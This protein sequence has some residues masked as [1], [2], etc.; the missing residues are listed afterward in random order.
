MNTTLFTGHYL[1]E[2]EEVDST[3]NY[4]KEM[5]AKDKP[6]EGTAIMANNQF[7]GRGQIGNSW[8][9][10]P[11]QNLTI[12]YLFYP[13]FL[14]AS[15]QFYLNMAVSLAVKDCCEAL[16]RDEVKI[17]WPNDIYYRD[18]KIGGILIENSICGNM[19]STS[20]VGIGLNVNQTVFDA[21]LP[22]PSS[23]KIIAGKE[24]D[25]HEALSTLNIYMEKYYL[26]LRQQHYNFLEKAYTVAMYRYQQ[27]HEFRKA[28]QMVRGE[29]NGVTKEGKLILHCNGK[30]QR[31]NFKEIEYIIP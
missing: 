1:V 21:S 10:E 13:G 7:S 4:L 25:R 18:T 23:L 16:L 17:K 28:N 6:S 24:F 22:N 27:T 5:L 26:Q 2:L 11:G 15:K 20:I 29:I 9:S 8:M 14:E 31:Y 19:L 12:S 3:N 30:E